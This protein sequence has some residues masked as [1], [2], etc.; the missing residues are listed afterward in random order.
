MFGSS[1]PLNMMKNMIKTKQ[2]IAFAGVVGWLIFFSC[3]A[4]NFNF[5]SE[6]AF[7]ASKQT[8]IIPKA[9]PTA[10]LP[11]LKIARIKVNAP[12][13][14]AGLTYF[15]EIAVPKGPSE[16]SWFSLGPRPGEI[17]SAIISGHYG[18][19]N[20]ISAVFDNLSK[21]KK[22]DKLSFQDEKGIVTTFIVRTIK[23]Y[24]RNAKATEV[25]V[26][27]DGKAHLNLITCGGTWNKKQKSY[28]NRLVVFTDK[29]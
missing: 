1:R 16:V 27:N 26:S 6:K 2:I 24:N 23:V 19:K 18:W 4:G 10:T 7:A 20:N 5:F 8:Q 14:S 11:R 3:L 28:S 21:L 13:I 17:G 12:V 15:G 29:I 22:G 25:F 9:L